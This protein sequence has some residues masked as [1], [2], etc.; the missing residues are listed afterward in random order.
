MNR[1]PFQLQ[2]AT[3]PSSLTFRVCIPQP[4]HGD[5]PF[6]DTLL[7]APLGGMMQSL[8]AS[9]SLWGQDGVCMGNLGEGNILVGSG[10]ILPVPACFVRSLGEVSLVCAPGTWVHHDARQQGAGKPFPRA[11]FPHSSSSMWLHPQPALP[12]T[13]PRLCSN[14]P[15]PCECQ[16]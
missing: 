13:S 5:Q 2:H 10:T 16:K 4:L 6:L 1:N 14:P 12:F 8:W 11:I 7:P 15:V 3:S 9:Q